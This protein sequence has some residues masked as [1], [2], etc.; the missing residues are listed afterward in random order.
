MALKKWESCIS[1]PEKKKNCQ[2]KLLYP[3]KLIPESQ[4]RNIDLQDKHR[5]KIDMTTK[6]ALQMI[7][8][9]SYT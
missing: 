1:S 7:L 6:S 4:R 9:E 2:S 8:K 5:I 3:S